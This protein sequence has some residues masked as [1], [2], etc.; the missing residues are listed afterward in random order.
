MRITYEEARRARDQL[1]RAGYLVAVEEIDPLSGGL[2]YR[3]IAKAF[4]PK[5]S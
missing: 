5:P 4:A 2:R 1:V 3:Y